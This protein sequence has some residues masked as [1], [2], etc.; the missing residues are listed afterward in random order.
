MKDIKE[1]I[2]KNIEEV[3]DG[4]NLG[5]NDGF[6]STSASA[7]VSKSTPKITIERPADMA[8]GDYSSNIAMVLAP[9]AKRSPLALS[10][11]I[12]EKL[13][14]A[15]DSGKLEE[16]LKVEVAG[17]GFINFYLS[18]KIYKE[19]IAAILNAGDTYGTNKTE[20]GQKIAFEYTDPNP[21]KVFHIGHLMSNAVGESLARLGEST[22]AEIKRFCY[23]GDVG[24]H[25]ALTMWGLRLMDKPLP[26]ES[27]SIK[28][29]VAYFGDAYALGATRFKKL[30]DESIASGQVTIQTTETG[31]LKFPNS[32]EFKQMESEVR[33]LNKKIYDRSDAEVN[34]I[35]DKGKEWSLK[36]FEEL[37]KILGTQFDRYFFESQVTEKGLE[38]VKA[39][40]A[41]KGAAIFEESNGAI[42]FPGEKYGLHTRV[43]VNK[44]GLPTYDG[45]EIGLVE[46]KHKAYNYDRSVIVTANEQDEYFKVLHKAAS[47]IFPELAPK[48][49]HVSHG[50]MR[51][52]TGKM[53]S[54]TGDVVT[55]ESL[56]NDMIEQ[57]LEKMKGRDIPENEKQEIA[58][59]VGVAAIKYTILRQAIGKDTIFDPEKSLSF[60]GDSGPYLQYA[61]VRAKSILAKAHEAGII[62]GVNE[63]VT[64]NGSEGIAGE[65]QTRLEKLLARYPET[66]ERAWTGLAPHHVAN[67]LME[68]AGTFN[69]F[70]ANTQIVKADDTTSPYKVALVE[71]FSI[72]MK[73]GL[74]VL[75]IRVPKRM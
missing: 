35:Y 6:A 20:K 37:Y 68:L 12:V 17:P 66:V 59:D 34:E 61:Y 46:I 15:L 51:L 29:K 42:I 28:E 57:S 67:Y 47:L 49:S 1:Q 65:A 19:N 30:E 31:E 10:I 69:A 45:K 26:E 44:D 18:P 36:H 14:E 48:M 74:N 58:T 64:K 63:D 39:N 3:V 60:E 9:R 40:T 23:Q 8:H 2:I 52:T 70:Y 24:R 32:P 27:A 55:G 38:L 71:A 50:M 22:G 11:E 56:I 75:G 13:R 16:V 25:V 73:N 5:L 21:F 72:V 4:L 54:R 62:K 33:E 7:S 53:S 43:Y 41:P